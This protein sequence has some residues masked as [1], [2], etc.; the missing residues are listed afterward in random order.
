MD[1]WMDGWMDEGWYVVPA[2]VSP[3]GEKHMS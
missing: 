1:G 2:L 3:I